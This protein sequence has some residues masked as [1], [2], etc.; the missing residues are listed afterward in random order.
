MTN[1]EKGQAYG[2]TRQSFIDK[3]T[4]K[5]RMHHALKMI[6][7]FKLSDID[8]R[9]VLELG[10][11]YQGSNLIDLVRH[12]PCFQCLGIDK[13]VNAD[14]GRNNI[15]LLSDDI[16]TWHPS[17]FFDIVLSL[18]VVEHLPDPSRHLRLIYQS[19]KPGGIAILSTPMPGAHASW[20][21]LGKLRLIDTSTGNA[22]MLYLTQQ[23]V[24]YLAEQAGLK[25]INQK[26][27]EFGLN[28]IVLLEKPK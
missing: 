20:S 6:A 1:Q 15:T 23:G 5:Q 16:T 18:A 24:N 19:L 28:Q 7:V 25:V 27:F 9:S 2:Q 26:L 8:E 12:Y 17:N 21:L 22:H 3:L 11:G 4:I 14:A 13:V 10:C